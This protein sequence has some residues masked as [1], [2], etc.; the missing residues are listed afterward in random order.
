M[1][2]KHGLSDTQTVNLMRTK[3]QLLTTPTKLR[4]KSENH[5]GHINTKHSE[6]MVDELKSEISADHLGGIE[7]SLSRLAD[8][9]AT[10]YGTIEAGMM[11]RKAL[12]KIHVGQPMD[13][14]LKIERSSRLV[15]TEKLVLFSGGEDHSCIATN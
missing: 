13:V 12:D 7:T 2:Q 9:L 3:L 15:L 10:E 14:I 8:S 11:L 1:N 6:A 5:M 4:E